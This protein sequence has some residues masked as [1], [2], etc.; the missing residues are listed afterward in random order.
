MLFE[1]LSHPAYATGGVEDIDQESS[2]G[3]E[4]KM[5]VERKEYKK[6]EKRLRIKILD[7]MGN[8]PKRSPNGF[9]DFVFQKSGDQK[10]IYMA[11]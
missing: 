9:F 2:F 5:R 4:L 7:M 3:Q 10:Y 1:V 6:G 8:S 11:G